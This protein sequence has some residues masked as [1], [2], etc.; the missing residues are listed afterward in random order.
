[1]PIVKTRY[2]CPNCG[3]Q[4][5]AEN[6]KLVCSANSNHFWVDTAAFIGL[7]PPVKYEESKP[8]VAPQTNHVKWEVTVPPR[9]KAALEAKFGATTESTIAGV[10]AMLSEG[11]VMMI[12]ES[13]LQRMKERFG[14]RPESSGEL[15]GLMYSMSMD[16]ETEKLTFFFK[17]TRMKYKIMRT[18]IN[19]RIYHTGRAK[20]LALAVPMRSPPLL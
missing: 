1:M 19:P 4:V 3:A 2:G 5:N 15:F 10:L 16:L 14:K 8:P 7:N 13:D 11:D 17:K 12:P 6:R 18:R 20:K 9:V